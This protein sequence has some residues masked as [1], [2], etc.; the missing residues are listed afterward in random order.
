MISLYHPLPGECSQFSD[1]TDQD[2]CVNGLCVDICQALSPCG[3]GAQCEVSEQGPVCFCPAGTLGDPYVSC[4]ASECGINPECPPDKLCYEGR[5]RNPCEL[6]GCVTNAECSV[7]DRAAVCACKPGYTGNPDRF[8]VAPPAGEC[9]LD[10]D[11]GPTL[12]CVDGS[13]V[14]LCQEVLPCG[15][16]AVCSVHETSI[17][18]TKRMS[19]KCPA[20][21]IGH[22][23]TECSPAPVGNTSGCS[24]DVDCPLTLAC[25]NGQ[26]MNPCPAGCGI[27]TQCSV[28][29]HR[30]LCHC[31]EGYAG[32]PQEQCYK[33][34]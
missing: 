28:V 12:G 1:C 8:C 30:P 13:C 22:P 24:S 10:T 29:E 14:S 5:C 19:C 32:N 25:N 2:F 26:C 7:V 18:G 15:I 6:Q 11:C 4:S 20:G 34:K 3:T 17:D 9:S 16:N 23:Y 27:N 31:M 33:S 21:F